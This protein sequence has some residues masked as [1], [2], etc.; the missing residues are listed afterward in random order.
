MSEGGYVLSNKDSAAIYCKVCGSHRPALARGMYQAPYGDEPN[1]YVRYFL[2]ECVECHNPS[3]FVRLP[4][5]TVGPYDEWSVAL[6][7]F[8]QVDEPLPL[9]VPQKI[10]DKYREAAKNMTVESYDS[11]AIMCRK[12]LDMVCRHFQ[13]SGGN[14]KQ[15]LKDLKAKGLIDDRIH[16]W[17]DGVLRQIGNDA[18]HGDDGA[19]QVDAK[20]AV[21]FC[22]A[23]L[24]HLFLFMPAYDAFQKRHPQKP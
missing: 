2:G 10:A 14:L 19:S 21:D 4:V 6:Q 12:V 7:L 15:Q 9:T 18:A 13:C 22:K 8:P 24:D 1:Y 5:D 17:A 23:V 3:V 11:A 20:D 16:L